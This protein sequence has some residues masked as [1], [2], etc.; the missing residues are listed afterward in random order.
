MGPHSKGEA[1][2]VQ[3]LEEPGTEPGVL[4]SSSL[5]G[6]ENWAAVRKG[7]GAPASQNPV[8]FPWKQ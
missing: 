4:M 6:H 8:V 3:L 7:S 2:E 5:R 1:S